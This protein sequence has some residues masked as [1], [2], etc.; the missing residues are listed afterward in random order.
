MLTVEWCKVHSRQALHLCSSV[1][2]ALL[3]LLLLHAQHQY[4]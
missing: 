4:R 1:L 3:L 2:V